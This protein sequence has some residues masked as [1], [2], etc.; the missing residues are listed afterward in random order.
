MSGY[1]K[2]VA[3]VGGNKA[4]MTTQGR[5]QIRLWIELQWSTVW[6]ETYMKR[7]R[8]SWLEGLF[9]GVIAWIIF[10]F[11]CSKPGVYS[12]WAN[13]L[14]II[15]G[16]I[17]SSYINIILNKYNNRMWLLFNYVLGL[18]CYIV[19][20]FGW[21]YMFYIKL[22]CTLFPSRELWTGEGVLV[23]LYWGFFCVITEIIRLIV[24]IVYYRKNK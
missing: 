17:L 8:I 19:V 24:L 14:V 15:M 21:P 11:L 5:E 2:S 23:I 3:D 10:D 12:I 7:Y 16:I 22:Q 1:L 4:S 18:G 9:R 6:R 20:L 13:L